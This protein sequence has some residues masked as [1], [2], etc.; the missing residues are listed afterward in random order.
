MQSQ[1]SCLSCK[2][3]AKAQHIPYMPHTTNCNA[4]DPPRPK[5]RSNHKHALGQRPVPPT[6]TAVSSISSPVHPSRYVATIYS[7]ITIPQPDTADHTSRAFS[8]FACMH[9][10]PR[11]AG[12]VFVS[13]SRRRLRVDQVCSWKV[14]Q[15]AIFAGCIMRLRACME[16]LRTVE[17]C[18]LCI[19]KG[20]WLR[21]GALA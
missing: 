14:S 9:M 6:S 10:Q 13:R 12:L 15:S 2:I 17:R 19:L 16:L 4:P 5:P 21:E 3:P 8:R 1:P 20:P 18:G 11:R 7:F